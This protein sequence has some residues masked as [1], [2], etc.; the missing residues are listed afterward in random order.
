MTPALSALLEANEIGSEVLALL[1]ADPW[2]VHIPQR[3]RPKES[4]LQ[5][6]ACA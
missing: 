6:G 5:L 1:R 3:Q 2:P 4:L